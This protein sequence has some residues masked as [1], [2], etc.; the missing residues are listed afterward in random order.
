MSY[1]GVDEVGR[2]CLAGPMV[3]CAVLNSPLFNDFNLIDSKRLTSTKRRKLLRE[4]LPQVDF[5]IASVSANFIDNF[6]ISLAFREALLQCYSN[7]SSRLHFCPY[8]IDGRYKIDLKFDHRFEYKAEDQYKAVAL[9]SIIAK[10]FRDA[11]MRD[12]A[13]SYSQYGFERHKGYGTMF[14]RKAI[15]KFG[16]TQIHRRSFKIKS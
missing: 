5:A 16:Y 7:L 15:Q 12:L 11:Y 4:L 9:A 2:G 1:I 3:V 10:E 13:S 6:G 14:H 8:I